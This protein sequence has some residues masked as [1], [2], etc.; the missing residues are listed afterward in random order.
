[1]ESAL[2]RPASGLLVYHGG[3]CIFRDLA[4]GFRGACRMDPLGSPGRFQYDRHAVVKEADVIGGFSGQYNKMRKTVLDPVQA[5]EQREG[6][7]GRLDGIF[8]SGLLP[9]RGSDPVGVI[10]VLPVP[11]RCLKIFFSVA[12]AAAGAVLA[13]RLSRRCTG[14]LLSGLS[15]GG[16]AGRFCRRFPVR[17]F[18]AHIWAAF[19]FRG[20]TV[21]VTAA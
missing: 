8:V 7:T 16:I 14:R 3:Q 9:V 19:T 20:H 15:A 6:R 17:F 10:A 5:G 11:D 13:A 2:R 18:S 4:Y 1:M 12:G 21:A